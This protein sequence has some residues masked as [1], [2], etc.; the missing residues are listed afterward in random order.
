MFSPK[1]MFSQNSTYLIIVYLLETS[2]GDYL[3]RMSVA[4]YEFLLYIQ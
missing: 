4:S 2:N 1:G 3:K